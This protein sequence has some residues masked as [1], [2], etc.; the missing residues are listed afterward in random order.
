MAEPVTIT[1]RASPH[2]PLISDPEPDFV[3]DVAGSPD[4]RRPRRSRRS[5][6]SR[7]AGP[8]SDPART[9]DAVFALN[10]ATSWEEF[11]RAASLF[12]VPAQNMVYAD[13]DGNIGYQAPG[14]IPIRTTATGGLPVPGWTGE[15]EWA[16]YV[17]FDGASVRAEPRPRVRGDCEPGGGRS[18]LPVPARRST[19]RT[20]IRSQRIIDLIESADDLDVADIQRMQMDTRNAQ[21]RVPG[22]RSCRRH[23]T[24]RSS[25]RAQALFDGWDYSQPADSAP[26][27]YF[28]AFWRNLLARTRSTT[29][30]PR[31]TGPTAVTGGSRWSA[32]SGRTRPTRGGTT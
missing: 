20:A 13:V 27:A 32:R 28:N 22:A 3:D 15:F 6:P 11:R 21:R 29:S 23:R 30:C 17:P 19:G 14:R 4:V 2:G 18:G 5:T 16:A 7:C 26:A 24:T 9:A 1:V 31:T 10:T 25:P 8:R 12:E